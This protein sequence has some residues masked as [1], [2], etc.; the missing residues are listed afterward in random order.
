MRGSN[1]IR[2]AVDM[3]SGDNGPE[4]FIPAAFRA[5][6]NHPNLTILAVGDEAVLTPL[7]TDK[8]HFVSGRLII[9]HA[10][11]V[12]E[13]DEKP[14]TALRNKR[15]SSMRVAIN[16]V[17]EGLADSCM[18]AGNTGALMATARYVLKMLPGIERPAIC[19][20]IP[21][22]NNGHVYMLDLGANVDNTAEHLHQFALMGS[23][24][25]TAIDENPSPKVALL[26]IGEEAIKGNELIKETAPLL[27][28][29]KRINYI[30]F[31]EGDGI[32]FDDVDVIV[33][34]GFI[35]N[36]ALKTMEGTAKMITRTLE[37]GFK[38][39]LFTKLSAVVAMPVLRALKENLDPRKHNGASLLGLRG[40]VVKSH[41][42]AD[43]VA[44]ENAIKIATK[45]VEQKMLTKMAEQFVAHQAGA[46]E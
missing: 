5:L 23:L 10:S 35:G 8:P 30:G 15:D 4:V 6:D 3:M 7:V 41:G 33:S 20:S 24:V 36:V 12:V 42:N 45:L 27:E 11:Q 44:F 39:N 29:E 22:M 19:T 2:V 14:Q 17:K 31:V 40:I 37:H 25:A 9:H 38:K 16:C 32:F 26:N 13:M 46:E 43:A 34:D 1:K 21:S 28:G 18:S